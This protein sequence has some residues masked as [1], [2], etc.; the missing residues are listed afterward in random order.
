MFSVHVLDGFLEVEVS[1]SSSFWSSPSAVWG[2]VLQLGVRTGMQ[3]N[4]ILGRPG[5][6]NRVCLNRGQPSMMRPDPS[7]PQPGQ[8]TITGTIVG[9]LEPGEVVVIHVLVVHSG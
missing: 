9:S 7:P 4:Q 6:L 1:S 5:N 8:P 2:G 3:G